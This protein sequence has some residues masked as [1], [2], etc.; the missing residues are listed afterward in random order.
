M[1]GE[2]T[3]RA[4][5]RIE[6][7]LD[8]IEAAARQPVGHHQGGDFEELRHRHER[9]RAAVQDGLEQLDALIEGA[10]G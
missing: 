7:A 9:L 6:A 10:Q 1:E 4:M 2:R 8:R 3:S 5:A